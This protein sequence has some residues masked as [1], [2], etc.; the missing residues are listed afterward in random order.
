MKWFELRRCWFAAAL[1][2]TCCVFLGCAR[3]Y[4]SEV[5]SLASISLTGSD[6]RT[7]E[8][9]RVVGA[10]RLTVFIFY[11]AG[12]PCLAA[13]EPRIA[14]LQRAFSGQ[15]VAFFLVNSEHGASPSVDA[16]EAQRRGLSV[17]LLT[18]SDARLARVLGAEFAT[19]SIV[20]D[21]RGRVAYSGGLDSDKKQLHPD[22]TPY[23]RHALEDALAGRPQRATEHEALGCALQ[24]D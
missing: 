10:H 4:R 11:A 3:S 17:P 14:E 15:D 12:C 7:Y 16:R 22:A 9:S 20:L 24:L 23:L 13:H 19:H 18:D 2:A 1:V 5:P 6:G 8:P 21:A